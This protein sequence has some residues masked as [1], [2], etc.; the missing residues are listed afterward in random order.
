MQLDRL[1]RRAAVLRHGEPAST[2]LVLYGIFD[3]GFICKLYA[4]YLV[5]IPSGRREGQ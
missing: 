1:C 3:C 2:E 5:F 4:P